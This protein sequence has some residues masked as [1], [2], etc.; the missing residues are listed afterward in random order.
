LSF[1]DF[2]IDLL[3]HWNVENLDKNIEMLTKDIKENKYKNLLLSIK[4][5][6]ETYK[7]SK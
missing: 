6:Y 7:K 3:S 2:L 5:D 4:N 1:Y